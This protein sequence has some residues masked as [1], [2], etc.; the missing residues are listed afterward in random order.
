MTSTS[1]LLIVSL[2]A[3]IT[4]TEAGLGPQDGAWLGL[5]LW[6]FV[7]GGGGWREESG[8]VYS[9]CFCCHSSHGPGHSSDE[10]ESINQSRLFSLLP[11]LCHFLFSLISEMALC[12]AP[13]G[14]ELTNPPSL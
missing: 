8:R 13:R 1:P 11:A 4:I 6:C 2:G 10:F 7:W 5:D 3:A 9:P 12:R 14:L